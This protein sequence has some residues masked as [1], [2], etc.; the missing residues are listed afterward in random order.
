MGSGEWGVES[1]E[2][3]VETGGRWA[4]NMGCKVQN[5]FR[6]GTRA[7]R[8]CQSCRSPGRFRGPSSSARP[9]ADG[10]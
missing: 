5:E 7:A 1:D 10:R 9:R 2:W 8:H 3:G 6:A 4:E